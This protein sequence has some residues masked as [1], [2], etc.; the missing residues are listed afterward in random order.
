[1]DKILSFQ[2]L[3]WASRGGRLM[4]VQSLLAAGANI[5]KQS[6]DGTRAVEHA[7]LQG[8]KAVG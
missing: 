6:C 1:M 2:A 3:M 4:V 7:L 8:H 5:G